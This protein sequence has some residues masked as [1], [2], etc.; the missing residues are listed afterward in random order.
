MREITQEVARLFGVT[1]ELILGRQRWQPLATA[2]QVAMLITLE[3]LPFGTMQQVAM[4]FG[5]HRTALIHARSTILNVMS[6]DPKLAKVVEV[7]RKKYVKTLDEHL[8]NV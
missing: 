1:E 4:Y 2:R 5:K 6:Y 7:L 8:K 3:S